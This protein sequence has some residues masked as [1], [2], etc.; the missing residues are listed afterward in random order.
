MVWVY[1]LNPPASSADVVCTVSAN[2]VG[3]T[4]IVEAWDGVDQATPYGDLTAT[5]DNAGGGNSDPN[6]LTVTATSGKIITD[7]YYQW[8]TA[9]GGTFSQSQTLIQGSAT[10]NHG[11]GAN[12]CCVGSSYITSDGSVDMTWDST[13]AAND[14]WCMYAI[15]FIAAA[16]GTNNQ[17]A[18]IRA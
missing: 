16:T 4:V 8:Q 9:T 14:T 2:S 12:T 7:C 3:K 11:G 18:W 1:Y 15:A 10:L 6:V 5:A 13:A 17:L